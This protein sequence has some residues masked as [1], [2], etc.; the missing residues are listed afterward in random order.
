MA[1]YTEL[2]KLYYNP[3]T[4]L[5]NSKKFY[6]TA[7]EN[8]L[9]FTH[10]QINDFVKKQNVDQVFKTVKRPKYFS[11]I[12][13]DGIRS[14]FQIDIIVY[15]RYEYHKYRYI[16]VIVDIHSRYACARAMTNRENPTIM[17]N[18]INMF[19]V[20]GIPKA[21]S[22]DNEFDT[23]EF[24]KYCLKHDIQTIYSE[25][26]D[27]LKNSIV[28]RLNRTLAGYI[29]KLRIG[30]KVYDWPKHLPE[31]MDNYNHSYHRT[32]RNTPYNIFFKGGENKQD[33]MI[34][35][36][37][38]SIGDSVRIHIPKKGLEKGDIQT[39]SSEVYR[40]DHI[41]DGKYILNNG[42][43]YPA[44]KLTKVSDDVDF[45]DIEPETYEEEKV[46]LKERKE[47]N[48]A[49][50]LKQV[51]I[52]PANELHEPRIRKPRVIFDI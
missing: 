7:R 3:K 41:E 46:Y 48:I 47:R 30:S 32:I 42:M 22:C 4:G 13:V 2:K 27:T 29:K 16:F 1:E 14:E 24:R 19:E 40:I 18:M 10:K 33:I 8:G 52:N 49:K 23:L 5:S 43:Y 26:Y 20:M 44:R 11:T 38:L 36:R 51:G 31:I 37:D 28:E 50:K 12:T 21:I 25:P 35:P 17:E 34:V 6:L 15:D 45:D 9:T 39:Y